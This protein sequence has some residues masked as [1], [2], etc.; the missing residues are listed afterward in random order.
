MRISDLQFDQVT[1]SGHV[2]E[3]GTYSL[4]TFPTLKSLIFE[5]AKGF[6]PNV[7][8]EKIDGMRALKLAKKA[9]ILGAG[10]SKRTIANAMH[11]LRSVNRTLAYC[12]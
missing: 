12:M 3:P 1:I 4:K 6:M 10:N 11:E 8:F 5:A 2:W 9:K 7:Y